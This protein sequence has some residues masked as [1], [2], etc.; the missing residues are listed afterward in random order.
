MLYN[1]AA[2][3][4]GFLL[5]IWSADRFVEG[6]AATARNLGVSTLIL[7]LGYGA[8]EVMASREAPSAEPIS[9]V[10]TDDVVGDDA[11]QILDAIGQSQASSWGI[12]RCFFLRRASATLEK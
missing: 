3:I 5:L 2:L 9:F 12:R 10:D 7:G 8:G 1:I 4:A 6:A 11:L